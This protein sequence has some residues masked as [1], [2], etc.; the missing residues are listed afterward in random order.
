[1]NCKFCNAELEEEVTLCPQCGKENA[2]EVTE[3]VAEEIPAE[4][5]AVEEIVEVAAETAETPKKRNWLV[6]ILAVIGGIALVA[7][8]VGA[9]YFGFVKDKAQE[10]IVAAESYSVDA[11]TAEK[12]RD[13]VVAVAGS[14]EL[15]NSELQVYYWQGINDFYNYYGYYMDLSTLGLDLSQ[16]LDQQFYDE[17]NGIT[18]QQYFLDIALDTW[19]RYAVL[20]ELAKQENYAMSEASLALLDTIPAEM[21]AMAVSYG[22]ADAADMLSKD[23]GPVSDMDGYMRF[24]ELNYYVGEYYDYVY[25]GLTPTM[26][27]LQAYYDENLEEVL[28]MGIE[29]DGSKYVDVRHILF[30]PTGGEVNSETG[31]TTYSEEEWEACRV[32]AQDLLDQWLAGEATEESFAQLAMEYSE[33]PGSQSAGGLYT[34]VYV[35][36]MVKPFED[37][38]FDES[39]EYGDSGL[40]QTTYGYHIMYFVGSEPIWVSELS[41]Q[42]VTQRSTDLVS[43]ALEAF[44]RTVYMEKI[45]LGEPVSE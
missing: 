27:E 41:T 31:A 18:W 29:D 39:R 30:K 32:K 24:L 26:E 10:T 34:D 40:V 4:E 42:L 15:T 44:P 20:G 25:A 21:N 16:P 23:M 14:W 22:Y 7:V 11:A 43:N 37:W 6:T 45:V 12:E 2:E 8:L 3:V 19:H 5:T 13:T 1:M 36:Q 35:G 38:C 17:A 9:I 28:A 33:D